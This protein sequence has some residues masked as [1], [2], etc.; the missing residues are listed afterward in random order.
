MPIT[1]RVQQAKAVMDFELEEQR[2]EHQKRVESLENALDSERVTAEAFSAEKA[3]QE[4]KL[5][6]Q[7]DQRGKELQDA[8]TRI[9]SLGA[10]L[11][12][13]RARRCVS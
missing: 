7:L 10:T 9:E 12:E 1:S 11:E 8:L 5:T 2:V 3:A 6:D 4:K 13:E